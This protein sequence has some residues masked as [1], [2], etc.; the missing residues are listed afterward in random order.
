VSLD[1]EQIGEVVKHSKA[2]KAEAHREVE[3]RQREATRKELERLRLLER[4]VG[5]AVDQWQAQEVPADSAL[6]VISGALVDLA[7]AKEEQGG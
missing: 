1:G 2:R 4:L 3:R 6:E 5:S 7:K